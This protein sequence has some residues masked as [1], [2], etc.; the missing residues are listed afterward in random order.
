MIHNNTHIILD[1]SIKS[2]VTSHDKIELNKRCKELKT[3]P[4]ELIRNYARYI[5]AG[6]DPV[7]QNKE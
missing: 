6:G 2:R 5:I 7:C 3:N 1:N 4:S